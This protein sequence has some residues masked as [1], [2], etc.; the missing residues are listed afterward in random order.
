MSKYFL[1]GC[2]H[3]QGSVGTSD[4]GI[5]FILDGGE[6]LI[7]GAA[8]VNRILEGE[9]KISQAHDGVVVVGVGYVHF[10]KIQSQI[11]SISVDTG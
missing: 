4:R 8:V 7:V 3:S 9:M 2:V 6:N 11:K 1:D 5:N 10:Q